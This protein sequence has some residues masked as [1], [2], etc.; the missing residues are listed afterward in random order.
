MRELPA[1]RDKVRLL[2]YLVPIFPQYGQFFVG[3]V[4]C[5]AIDFYWASAIGTMAYRNRAV[6]RDKHVTSF[7]VASPNLSQN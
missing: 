7:I 6:L 3:E 1:M 4:Y 2:N 5:G